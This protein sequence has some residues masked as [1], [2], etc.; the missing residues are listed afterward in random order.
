MLD[1]E[2]VLRY[3]LKKRVAIQQFFIMYLL[4]RNDFNMPDKRSLGKLYIHEFGQFPRE[5]IDDL[6]TRGFI[7]DCNSPGQYFPELLM[8]TPVA[9]EQFAGYEMAEQLWEGYPATFRLGDK[10]TRFIARGGGDKDELLALYL[11][12]I[13]FSTPKHAFVMRQV[14]RFIPMVEAG[15]INGYKLSDWIRGELWD[16]IAAVESAGEGGEFGKDI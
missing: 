12:K 14:A 7:E 5:I 9:R 6:V 13:N 11:Q 3:C 16:T 10:G 1:G 2:E 4:A 8:L 15:Q